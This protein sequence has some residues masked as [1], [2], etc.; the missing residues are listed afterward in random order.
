[1]AV[2]AEELSADQEDRTRIERPRRQAWIETQLVAAAAMAIAAAL[3]VLGAGRVWCRRRIN[4]NET[5]AQPMMALAPLTTAGATAT[6][7]PGA[8]AIARLAPVLPHGLL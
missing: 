6:A 7:T 2:A 5:K 3:L 4:R 8:R 1:M